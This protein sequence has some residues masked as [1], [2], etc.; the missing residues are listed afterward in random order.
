MGRPR[1]GN[2]I[3]MKRAYL[4]TA[5]SFYDPYSAYALRTRGAKVIDLASPIPVSVFQSEPRRLAQA[6]SDILRNQEKQKEQ[7]QMRLWQ[8]ARLQRKTDFH[9]IIVMRTWDL[10]GKIFSVMIFWCGDDYY[11]LQTDERRGVQGISRKYRR[12][13]CWDA[14]EGRREIYWEHVVPYPDPA[15]PDPS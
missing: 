7:V 4:K 3:K 14:V 15:S 6:E 2:A 5:K 11:I 9:Q 1:R 8:S 13:E 10:K 12:Q